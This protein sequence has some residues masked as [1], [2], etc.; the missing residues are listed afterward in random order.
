MAGEARRAR[1]G[2]PGVGA[3]RRQ[4]GQD[5][6]EEAKK[7]WLAVDAPT[8]QGFGD[9]D[10]DDRGGCE[11]GVATAGC[12]SNAPQ[13]E[14]IVNDCEAG[15]DV[16]CGPGHGREEAKKAWLAK[17]DADVGRSAN[18]AKMTEEAAKKAWLAKLD[19][20]SKAAG[21]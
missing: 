1:L 14:T 11:E 5:P 2:P 9:R 7:A 20:V 13:V 17:L 15:N 3:R 18:T 16:A 10:Q 4:G 19:A 8:G 12:A 21:G 6:E